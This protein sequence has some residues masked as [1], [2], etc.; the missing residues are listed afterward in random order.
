LNNEKQIGLALIQYTQ[1]Y[2]ESYPCFYWDTNL[3]TPAWVP[4][5]NYEPVALHPYLKSAGIWVCPSQPPAETWPA[6]ITSTLNFG[7]QV[8]GTTAYQPVEYLVNDLIA[9]RLDKSSFS[10]ASFVPVTISSLVAPSSA[11]AMGEVNS[12]NTSGAADLSYPP[13]HPTQWYAGSAPTA[14][15]VASLHNNGMNVIYCDGHTKWLSATVYENPANLSV[16][17]QAYAN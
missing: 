12:Q 13:Q 10:P 9:V 6:R 5:A 14:L 8:P 17:Y 1:D 3:A 15:R 11:I 4:K 16:W 7:W 2:D